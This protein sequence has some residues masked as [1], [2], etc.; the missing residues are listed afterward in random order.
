[1]HD[2]T[3]NTRTDQPESQSIKDDATVASI[4]VNALAIGVFVI[5]A[6]IGMNTDVDSYS[7]TS[8]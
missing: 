4:S 7:P 3:R 2:F 6:T 5:S 8:M 1:M